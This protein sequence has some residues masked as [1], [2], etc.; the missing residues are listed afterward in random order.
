MSNRNNFLLNEDKVQE[1]M[2]T[3]KPNNAWNK[4]ESI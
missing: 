3:N 4:V 1:K 2:N